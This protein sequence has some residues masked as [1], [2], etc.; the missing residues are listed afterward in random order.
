[1]KK[2][3]QW[4][5][6][7]KDERLQKFLKLHD[8][9]VIA[10]RNGNGDDVFK[11][12]KTKTYDR[13]AEHGYNPGEDEKKYDP[14]NEGYIEEAKSLGSGI[15]HLGKSVFDKR[16]GRTGV[17]QNSYS[18]G[19][20]SIKWK[21]DKEPTKHDW[22]ETKNHIRISTGK[23]EHKKYVSE[24]DSNVDYIEEGNPI[25][26]E[27][28]RAFRAG[29]KYAGSGPPFTNR[30]V[31]DKSKKMKELA[32]SRLKEMGKKPGDALKSFKAGEEDTKNPP[33]YNSN[34][35]D[36]KIYRNNFAKE[37]DKVKG[38]GGFGGSGEG[39]G[40]FRQMLLK[41]RQEQKK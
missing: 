28:T 11:A 17:V 3:G 23:D 37:R 5:A 21:G 14:Q 16:N 4:Y 31:R 22:S 24:S 2:F 6:N 13:H 18:N 30:I 12:S 29:E 34:S 26:K 19:S 9:K 15:N 39:R 20:H 27:K 41:K 25:N 7:P 32:K 35:P 10:D 40:Y 38:E 8:P 1:M 33:V 36:K